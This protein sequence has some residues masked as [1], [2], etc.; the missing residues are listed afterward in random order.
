[1]QEKVT[2]EIEGLE[3]LEEKE[4]Y[5]KKHMLVNVMS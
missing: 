1:L 3:T 5:L 2:K 4:K